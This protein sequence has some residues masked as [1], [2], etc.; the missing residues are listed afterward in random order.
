[1]EV[2]AMQKNGSHISGFTLIELLVVIAIIA[3]LAAIL[4][5]VLSQ[6]REAANQSS[7]LNNVKQL[8]MAMMQY[9]DENNGFYPTVKERDSDP[10]QQSW[11]MMIM[12]YVKNRSAF[13]CRSD[14]AKSPYG[15]KS[16]LSYQYNWALADGDLTRFNNSVT[17]AKM[18]IIKR[19]SRVVCL[20]EDEFTPTNWGFITVGD[21]G[22][23]FYD[24]SL[25]GRHKRG[26]TFLL[27]DGHAKWYNTSTVPQVDWS[28]V[29]I[30]ETWS[31]MSYNLDY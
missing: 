27:A 30:C 29:K 31:G 16:D 25:K 26:D 22:Y 28:N 4:F 3:I 9:V 24:Y 5:P 2:N 1:M 21:W 6:A 20:A 18:S 12:R 11:C 13:H 8:G 17:P 19:P 10:P 23:G 14:K 15:V 7:C